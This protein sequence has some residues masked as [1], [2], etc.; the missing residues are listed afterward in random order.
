MKQSHSDVSSRQ[1]SQK[2]SS[3]TANTK[4]RQTLTSHRAIYTQVSGDRWNYPFNPEA[5]VPGYLHPQI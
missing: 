1:F 4:S 5:H 2:E 3:Q